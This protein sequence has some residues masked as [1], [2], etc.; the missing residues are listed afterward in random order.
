MEKLVMGGQVKLGEDLLR[1]VTVNEGDVGFGQINPITKEPV[2]NIPKYFTSDT[3]EEM[4]DDLFRNMTLL[5]EMAIRYEYLSDVEDQLRLILRTEANKEA[6]KTSYFGK[7]KYKEDGTPETTSDN[8]DNTKLIRDMMEAII[9]GHKYVESETFDQLLGNLGGFGKKLNEKLGLKIF[10]ENYDSAQISLNKSITQ[11]NN[12]FQIKTLGLNPLSALSN[13]LGGSFQ[14]VINAGTYFTKSEFMSNEFLITSRMNGVNAEKYLKLLEY[15]LPLTENNNQIIA[16]DLSRSRFSQE[17]V[18]DFL[19]I[20]MRESDQYVQ[21]VNFFSYLDNTVVIDGRVEN[22]RE[23]LRKTDKYKNI[24]N[25]S[26]EERAVLQAEFEEDVKALIKEKGVINN[27]QLVDGQLTI[28]GVERMSD[29]VIELRRKVQKLT[30]DALGNLS[31]DDVRQINLNIYGKS[32]MMFKNWI[33]R[34]VDVRFGNLKYNNASEAYEWG[35]TRTVFRFLSFNII[36]TIDNL[37]NIA[38]ATDEGVVL[39][40]DLFEKKKAEYE[41]ETGKTL[42]MDENQFI[43]LVKKN[44]IDQATDLVF[45]LTLWLSTLQ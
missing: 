11:L 23:Y 31:A 41:R 21:T 45:Y 18:Q 28:P 14:S 43:E 36:K 22:V 33:P 35:R 24:Y 2:Y 16:K 10:P 40:K 1:Q 29:S 12:L 30:K 19:M 8:S 3:G 4:S 26:A 37:V 27:A 39:M 17:S 5:N 42:R 32:F 38:G 44:V 13:F 15:F 20:L 7:T 25:I 34:L 9:Y 6:I